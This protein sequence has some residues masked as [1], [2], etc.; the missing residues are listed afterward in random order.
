M[1][2][3][4][5]L[6]TTS[7]NSYFYLLKQGKASDTHFCFYNLVFINENFQ[8]VMQKRYPYCL[9]CRMTLSIKDCN[10]W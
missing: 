9:T 2:E 4:A 5:R 1:E 7:V 10:L 8:K 3:I 6:L